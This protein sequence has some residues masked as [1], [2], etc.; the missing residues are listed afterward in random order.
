MDNESFATTQAEWRNIFDSI[1]DGTSVHDNEYTIL[2]VN[3]SLCQML[4]KSRDE[5]VGQK[6]YEVFHGSDRP[7]FE[8]PARKTFETGQKA[9]CQRFG[10]IEDKW[11]T[12]VTS[13][14]AENDTVPTIIHSVRDTT[15]RRVAEL[16]TVANEEKYR[17]LFEN[18]SDPTFIVRKSDKRLL[19]VNE[20]GAQKL[21]YTKE[22]LLQGGMSLFDPGAPKG[23]FDPIMESLEHT[24][25]ATFEY[26]HKL[27]SG[28]LIPIE[29]HTR[30]I[31]HEGESG[32]LHFVRDIRERK[33]AERGA[34]QGQFTL[35]RLPGAVSWID[36]SGTYRFANPQACDHFELDMNDLLGKRVWDIDPV[37]T[38]DK[39]ADHWDDLV[40]KGS[41]TIQTEH[42]KKDGTVF[43]VEI[44]L[45]IVE[46][47]GEMFNVIFPRDISDRVESE[48][49]LSESEQ[50]FRSFVE[51]TEECICNIG[52]DGHF[53]Y[54]SPGGL[55][56][57]GED[58]QS[59]QKLTPN[60]IA[61]PAYHELLDDMFKQGMAGNTGRFR[62]E[63]E[64]TDGVFWFESVMSPVLNDQGEITSLVRISRNIQ[65]QIEAADNVKSSEA[66]YRELFDQASD[67]IFVVDA[68]SFK[69]VDANQ[70]AE[71]KLGYEEGQLVGLALNDVTSDTPEQFQEKA[72]ALMSQGYASFPCTH[73]RSD[74][75]TFPTEVTAK[76]TTIEGRPVIQVIS[77]DI[78]ERAIAERALFQSEKKFR[79][80]IESSSECICNIDLD[81][82]FTYM[83]PV[84]LDAHELTQADLEGMH[85]TELAELDYHEIIQNTLKQSLDTKAPVRFKHQSSTTE[86]VRWF[87]SIL[88]PTINH[89]KEVDGFIRMSRDIQDQ[90]LADERARRH[91]RQVDALRSIDRA[92]GSSLDLSLVLRVILDH[93]SGELNCDASAI[94]L[95]RPESNELR[96]AQ[97]RGFTSSNPEECIVHV[98]EG[99]AGVAALE[100]KIITSSTLSRE[101]IAPGQVSWI[102]AEGFVA[103]FAAPLMAKGE[104]KGVL[105]VYHRAPLK[106]DSNWLSFFETL[107]GQAAIAIDNAALFQELQ[108][109]NS[110]LSL[111][112][113]T[114]L[115]AW[116]QALDIRD[117]ETEGHSRRVLDLTVAVARAMG[118]TDQDMKHVRRGALLH[119]LGKLV[120]PEEIHVKTGPLTK[121]EWELMRAHPEFTYNALSHIRSLRPALDIPYCHHERWDGQGYPRGIKGEEI[122]LTARIFA[123]VDAYDSLTSGR[124]FRGPVGRQAALDQIRES[125]GTQFD[126]RIVTRFLEVE[127]SRQQS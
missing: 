79:T 59:I 93:V 12:I 31:D 109:S 24:G 26:Q 27:K 66:K 87:E 29:V 38:E 76:V 101:D 90:R 46:F 127:A 81:G 73:K 20:L 120:C 113:D 92:I 18:A 125:A 64:T 70:T 2:D 22:E 78:S 21:G 51:T 30:V 62:Y 5:M 54:M 50:K 8:C 97:T 98:G 3:E 124:P 37:Y 19:D 55:E 71:Q 100:R 35:D 23:F 80:F 34:K 122:P 63:S 4:D 67:S 72:A 86:G 7:I 13:P 39:W 40:S 83:S 15:E 96:Y 60:D 104:V 85:C 112:Y 107:A 16:E 106:P 105:E 28:E 123:I 25:E 6:C 45:N 33:A 115:E 65:D 32:Y 56:A 44:H 103:G 14:I 116:A 89:E 77:R 17:N 94:L 114:T 9:K 84:G 53:L 41:M 88:T 11:T 121:E 95:R 119:D 48:R 68:E 110:D 82:N 57:H 117:K 126:P 58:L 102:E 91:M 49:L 43:P 10:D 1:G 42:I 75:S 61:E 74:G 111:A 118:I 36:S 52:P 99:N 69:I 47:E 108:V